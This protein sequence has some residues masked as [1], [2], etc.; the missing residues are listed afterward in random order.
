[1]TYRLL[2]VAVLAAPAAL[3]PVASQT[4]TRSTAA[5]VQ[6]ADLQQEYRQ[7]R[8][9][10]AARLPEGVVLVIGAPEPAHDYLPFFQAPAFY[11]LTGF[12]E[13]GAALVMV[14]RGGAVTATMFVQPRIP[15]QE[16]WSGSRLGTEGVARLMGT[17]A[18]PA[19][20][21]RAALDSLLQTRLPLHVVGD[22]RGQGAEGADDAAL[23]V[24]EQLVESLRRAHARLRV[25]AVNDIV[26]QMRG[27]K[28][29]T[30]LA[31]IRQAVE[32][33]VRAHDE[34]LRALEPGMNEFEL[35]ALI[36]YT[37]RRN[38]ADRPGFAS[39]VG[40]GPNSTTLHYNAN[41]RFIES[42]DVV[43]MDIGAS[44]KGY[45]ADVTR[46]LP[47]NGTFSPEQRAIYQLVRDAQAAAERQAKVGA[48]AARMGDSASATLAAG[49]ARLGLIE[50][51]S[52]RYDCDLNGA[53]LECPQLALYYMHGL[54]HGIGLE[55]HDPDQYYFTHVIRQGSAFT[56]EPGVYVR[57]N[58]LDVLPDTPRNRALVA[59]LRPVVERYKNIGVRIE[60]DYIVTD[61]G[62]EWISRAPREIAEIERLMRGAYQGPAPRDAA[63]VERYRRPVP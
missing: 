2:L 36:E 34:A 58:V 23:T 21:L 4:A 24:D 22:V 5:P 41:D 40:S 54:G 57:A 55:V 44:Y 43:V 38:G 8:E 15:A 50:S 56:L 47:A 10:L 12:R 49:L 33:T 63:A 29:P 32:V 51:P 13:A 31:F 3:L 27:T 35:Q 19:P 1:M 14:K 16:V 9:A 46:T 59:R 26:E 30:E 7:R 39:I 61:R 25:R 6:A 11:Y 60:D 48:P 53:R 17:A 37:F 45:S 62:V 18:R 28:S 42:G 52:A 20:Q